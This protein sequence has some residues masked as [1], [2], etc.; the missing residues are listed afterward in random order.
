MRLTIVGGGLAG[1]EAAWQAAERGIGVDLYEMRPEQ[2]T[3]AHRTGNLAELV[4]SNSLGSNLPNRASGLLKEELRRL[5]SLLIACG[6]ASS[7]PAGGALAV[8][9]EVFSTCVQAK[10]ENHSNIR[11]IREE[12]TEIPETPAVLAS[13]PLTSPKLLKALQDFSG[14]KQLFF[15]DAIAPIVHF[16]SINMEVAYRANRYDLSDSQDGDYIN[17]PLDQ[18]TYHRF[19]EALIS[20]KRIPLKDFEVEIEKG[21][22]AG[23]GQYFQGC[24]PVEVI[25]ATG[26]K[27]LAFGPMR[28]A[29]LPNPRTGRW[30][31]AVVQLRQDNLAAD[32]FNIVG[33]QTNL[34]FSEQER[35][36]RL[37]PGLE[38]ASFERFGQMHRNAY[39]TSPNLLDESLAFKQ[40]A[41]LFAAG[42]LSGIEGYAG[43]IVSGLVVGINAARFIRGLAPL[44]LPITTMTGALMHYIS[45]AE[46]K[47]FQPMKA[48]FGLLPKPEDDQRRNKKDRY[49]FYSQR[50]LADLEQY[51]LAAEGI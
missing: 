41:G 37:I 45:H 18:E 34:L 10:I 39:I 3:G 17:C 13:G 50:A 16:D 2:T 14:E 20:S 43:N 7:L 5:G 6:D 19:R 29:G 28:P 22:D 24:Q 44:K 42:Q 40:Q 49:L 36:F 23:S 11:L 25:A 27:S 9:R 38:N 15:Y 48:M 8:D 33:F 4:C 21:V 26:E 1:C 46:A 35:V 31:Y 32:L 30:P 51:L 47:D 12:I